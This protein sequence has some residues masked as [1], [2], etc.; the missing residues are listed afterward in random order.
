M[1]T[2]ELYLDTR[3]VK[4]DG[5]YPLKI[6]VT[7]ERKT[8]FFKPQTKEHYSFSVKAY[9]KIIVK[10]S[11]LTDDQERIRNEILKE[12][13]RAKR[14]KSEMDNFT[15]AVFQLRFLGKG[16]RNDLLYRLLDKSKTSK[17]LGT[18]RVYKGVYSALIHYLNRH[19]SKYTP[20]KKGLL[21]NKEDDVITS[22]PMEVVDAQ[23]LY[24]FEK[25][26]LDRG[27]SSTTTSIFFNRISVVFNEAI[28]SKEFSRDKYPFGKGL[29]QQKPPKKSKKFMKESEIEAFFKYETDKEHLQTTKD[30]FI[31]SY[32]SSGMNPID[33]F[34]LKWSDFNGRESFT[35]TRRKTKNSGNDIVEVTI[36]LNSHHWEIIERLGSRKIGP[37]D[38]VF[39]ILKP[40]MTESEMY[41][42]VAKKNTLYNRHLKVIGA[43]IGL[44]FPLTLYHARHAYANR[45]V[46][47][48]PV[49][50][51]SKQLGHSN[52]QTTENY[53]GQ[54][55]KEESLKYEQNLIP[56]SFGA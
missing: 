5:T 33:M 41:K 18:G 9:E 37:N 54:F 43:E 1:A 2:I 27:L 8:K 6:R 11:R 31:F 19:N 22:L 14:I 52:I 16:D 24:D 50:Y 4:I 35:F 44:D 38:Y 13:S 7:H 47:V 3:R 28:R 39:D 40:E 36:Y 49:A 25:W 17:N 45:L 26:N 46:K 20:G 42:A 21:T 29:F 12:L 55:E 53:L 32:L 23:W 10:G 51:I 15:F 48:A 34:S 30:F 56:N